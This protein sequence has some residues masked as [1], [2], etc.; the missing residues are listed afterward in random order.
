MS[1]IDR[2]AQYVNELRASLSGRYVIEITPQDT[3]GMRQAYHS[4]HGREAVGNAD[5]VD[6]IGYLRDQG[7]DFGA[8]S[9]ALT[10][11][12][13]AAL[14]EFVDRQIAYAEP[15]D[16]I[17][18]VLADAIAR[19]VAR[20]FEASGN[21]VSMTPLASSTVARKGHSRIGVE[22]GALARGLHNANARATRG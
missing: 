22:S 13:V 5:N 7:R 9:A 8:P 10:D 15:F 1:D 6:I 11:A 20:R 17:D 2:V 12:V 16:G 18:V 21:D 3:R 14:Q 4:A 19:G